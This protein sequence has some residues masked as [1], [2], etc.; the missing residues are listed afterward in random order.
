MSEF[1]RTKLQFSYWKEDQPIPLCLSC[2]GEVEL[3][4]HMTRCLTHDCQKMLALVVQS[5]VTWMTD[6]CVAPVPIKILEEYLLA[7]DLKSDDRML[8]H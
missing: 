6:T 8:V 3:A 2:N 7:Q 4:M 1:Y 5:L